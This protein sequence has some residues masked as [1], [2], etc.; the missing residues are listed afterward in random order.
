MLAKFK[1]YCFNCHFTIWKNERIKYSGKA[2]HVNCYEALKDETP[3]SL[4]PKYVGADS[5]I[6]RKQMVILIKD[7]ANKRK[8]K[9]QNTIGN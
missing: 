3:R 8:N 9:V 2:R 1:G 7:K 4:N 6:S 5:K